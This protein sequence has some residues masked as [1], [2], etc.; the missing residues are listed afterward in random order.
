[1]GVRGVWTHFRNLF[2]RIEPTELNEPLKIG[3]DMLSLLYTYR[4]CIDDFINLINKWTEKGHVVTC[5]W[6][7][8][9]PKEKKEIIG[10]RRSIRES[11]LDKKSDLEKYLEEYGSELSDADIKHIKTAITSFSW[12]GWHLTGSLKREIQEKLANTKHV[13]AKGEA[14]DLLLEMSFSKEIDIVASLDS[15]MFVMGAPRIWR[16]INI[17]REWII[18]DISVEAIC[19]NWGISLTMLQDASFLAGWDR[20][21]SQAKGGY[22]KFDTALTRVKYYGTWKAV[23]DK[24]DKTMPSEGVIESLNGLKKESR[25][26]WQQYLNKI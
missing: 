5:V 25:E 16:I 19:D 14:D 18:E 9:A 6:D 8:V 20:C 7:G 12:Q 22:M 4:S 21:Y 13:Y 26:R 23:L 2:K 24:M 10:E 15:D 1:M 11:A 3:I 17:R